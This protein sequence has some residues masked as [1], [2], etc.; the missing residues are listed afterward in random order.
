MSNTV[1]GPKNIKS[2]LKSPGAEQLWGLMASRQPIYEQY[3]V[4]TDRLI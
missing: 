3:Q 2:D 1:E 4:S